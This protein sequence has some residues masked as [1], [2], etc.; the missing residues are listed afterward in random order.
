[1]A[2][3]TQHALAAKTVV[4]GNAVVSKKAVKATRVNTVARA[5]V[6]PVA[7]AGAKVQVGGARKQMS[8]VAISRGP[9]LQTAAPRRSPLPAP[10]GRGF[11]KHGA[12]S[13]NAGGLMLCPIEP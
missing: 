13:P 12:L 7:I 6:A 2:S 8:G 4:R 9:S 5:A 11:A 3:M 10:R 1:M